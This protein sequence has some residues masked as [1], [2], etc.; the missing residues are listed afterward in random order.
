MFRPLSLPGTGKANGGPRRPPFAPIYSF[1]AA[2]SNRVDMQEDSA[3]D[4]HQIDRGI[5]APAIDL[6]VE[7]IALAF[8]EAGQPRTLDC[9]DMHK[10]VR[11][12]IVADEEAKA[13]HRVE[14][15]D[16]PGS[17]VSRQLARG[18]SP[19]IGHFDHR[20]EEHTSELQSL[21]RISYA[22]FCLKKKK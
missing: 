10:G 8:V 1:P 9:A 4:R 11:L 12:A 22:V 3:F 14:E 7:F 15:L 17:L 16:R 6:E 13:L 18:G 21:M 19:A 2:R 5:L 20:S